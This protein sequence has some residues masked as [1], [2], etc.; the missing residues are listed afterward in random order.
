MFL[1]LTH[2]TMTISREN[3]IFL[4]DCAQ[5]LRE[6]VAMPLDVNELFISGPR[7]SLRLLCIRS[8]RGDY[9]LALFDI[10]ADV[11]F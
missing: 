11:A 9:H 4:L 10:Q 8:R 1:N 3:C 5:F 7:S 2:E 6:K